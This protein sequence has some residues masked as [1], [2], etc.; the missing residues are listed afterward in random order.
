LEKNF[1]NNIK[2]LKII[3]TYDWIHATAISN[4]NNKYKKINKNINIIKFKLGP[5]DPNNV[6]NK[7]PATILAANRIANVKGRII[8]LTVSIIT[9]TGIKNLGV[10]VGTKWANKLL[11]W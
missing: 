11:Y 6:N 4:I 1:V 9:I 8:F 2:N 7:W 10:P 5:W 3:K